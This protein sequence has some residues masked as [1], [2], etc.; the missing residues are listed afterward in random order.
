MKI[1]IQS[2][3]HALNKD[4]PARR[5]QFSASFQHKVHDDEKFMSKI[6]WSDEAT[7]T[8]LRG[9]IE[10]SCGCITVDT[11]TT[12]ARAQVRRTQN[13]LQANGWQL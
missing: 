7:L 13:C 6:V 3:L 11:L 2:L 10:M 12:V 5:V 1:C 4:D 8:T 9:D